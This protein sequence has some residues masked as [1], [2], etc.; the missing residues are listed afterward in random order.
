MSKNMVADHAIRP[1]ENDTIFTIS[2]KANEAVS[3]YGPEE[4]INSSMGVLLEDNG[5]FVAFENVYS[6]LKELNNPQIAAY[7]SIEGDH[8]FLEAVK[9]A[10]FRDCR[11][12]A[13][14]EAIATPGGSGAVHHAIYNYSDLG[15]TVLTVSPKSE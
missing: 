11:P 5:D 9:T 4:V 2:A 14:I 7:A 6:H 12:D 3:K 8:D 13:Y 15:D 10:C 1:V